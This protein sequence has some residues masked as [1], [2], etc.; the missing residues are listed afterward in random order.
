[1]KTMRTST[2]NKKI[3]GCSSTARATAQTNG[4]SRCSARQPASKHRNAHSILRGARYTS[5]RLTTRRNQKR[6]RRARLVTAEQPR[7]IVEFGRGLLAARAQVTNKTKA[8]ARE[9]KRA[10][11]CSLTR[12][13]SGSGH[14]LISRTLSS[15][16]KRE[17]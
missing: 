6:P 8:Y 2:Q 17:G 10:Q 16:S 9:Q 5:E 12:E 1:M 14:P 15:A 4:D 7:Y 11:R 3:V 13:N